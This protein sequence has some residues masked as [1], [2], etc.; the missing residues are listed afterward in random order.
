M[1]VDASRSSSSSSDA[2]AAAQAGGAVILEKD[3]GEGKRGSFGLLHRSSSSSGVVSGPPDVTAGASSLMRV[4]NTVGVLSGDASAKASDH[5][6]DGAVT[7]G[8][9]SLNLVPAAA[10]RE[11]ARLTQPGTFLTLSNSQKAS[12]KWLQLFVRGS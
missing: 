4:S 3:R 6:T 1:I 7:R 12:L 9:F 11:G 2:S 10:A 5:S 8:G